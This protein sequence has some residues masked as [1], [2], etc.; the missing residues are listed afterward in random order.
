V[1]LDSFE[2]GDQFKAYML[3]MMASLVII[4]LTDLLAVKRSSTG[5]IMD[6]HLRTLIVPLIYLRFVPLRFLDK[7]TV[8]LNVMEF[9]G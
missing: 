7:D 5:S 9:S 6:T 8:T 4:I 2:N 3:G 1:D